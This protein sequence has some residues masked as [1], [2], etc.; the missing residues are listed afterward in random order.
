MAN[1]K[2]E[3]MIDD[4]RL[5]AELYVDDAPII[6]GMILNNPGQRAIIQHAKLNGQLFFGTLPYACGFENQCR[7]GDLKTFDLAYYPPRNQ[8]CFLYGVGTDEPL[9][10]SRI[11]RIVE[12][13]E[14]M[15]VIGIKNWLKQGSMMTIVGEAE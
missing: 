10:I 2:V 11:G 4:V 13:M 1:K 6:C 7:G 5:V 8:L 15:Q 12:G 9:P 3:I 14:G